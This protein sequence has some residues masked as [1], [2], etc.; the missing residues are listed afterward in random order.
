[1]TAT[2][3]KTVYGQIIEEYY[4]AGKYVVYIDNKKT[5]KSYDEIKLRGE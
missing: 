2:R 3:K 5:S 4:W 1:M